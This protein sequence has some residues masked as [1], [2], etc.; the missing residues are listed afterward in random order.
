VNFLTADVE[1]YHENSAST[2]KNSTRNNIILISELLFYF[3]TLSR[4]HW[5]FLKQ[6]VSLNFKLNHFLLKRKN[7]ISLLNEEIRLFE[8]KQKYLTRIEKE[9][10]RKPCSAQNFLTY[11]E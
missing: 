10:K 4:V 8:I 7:E 6:L 2:A 3:K 5:Y 11:V 9:F 1:V